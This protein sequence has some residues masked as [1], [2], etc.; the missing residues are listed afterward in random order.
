VRCIYQLV[1]I[2][3]MSFKYKIGEQMVIGRKLPLFHYDI[4]IRKEASILVPNAGRNPQRTE[5]VKTLSGLALLDLCWYF[6]ICERQWNRIFPSPVAWDL[7][8]SADI[9][10][11][12]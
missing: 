1:P 10:I 3:I 6:S 7:R 5:W 12:V 2:H 8:E 11:S 9:I 4:S